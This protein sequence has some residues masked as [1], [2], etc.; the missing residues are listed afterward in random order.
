MMKTS[1]V[2]KG[3]TQPGRYDRF[4]FKVINAPC[5]RIEFAAEKCFLLRKRA[6]STLSFQR[7][8]SQKV[9]QTIAA[10][11]ASIRGVLIV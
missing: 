6:P 7:I 9:Q 10:S 8:F 4:N 11:I 5:L 1:D 3:K 2:K